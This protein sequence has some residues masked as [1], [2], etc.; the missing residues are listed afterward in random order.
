GEIVTRLQRGGV[1]V[2]LMTEPAWGEEGRPNGLGEDPNVRLSSYMEICRNV[3][4]T[5]EVPLVD[6]FAHWK[7]Q[8]R[9][10]VRL[11]DWTTDGCH[12]NPRGHDELARRIFNVI[13]P[14]MQRLAD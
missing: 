11:Q 7:A 8:S 6:H 4:R 13:L 14:T 5:A 1:T 9:R 2:V 10:G 3:A 12:P